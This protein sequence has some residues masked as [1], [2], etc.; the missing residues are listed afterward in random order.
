MSSIQENITALVNK[1]KSQ[2]GY[3]EPHH[4]N[5]NKYAEWIDKTYPPTEWYNGRKNVGGDWCTIFVDWCFLD[6]FGITQATKILNRDSQYGKLAAVVQYMY[7]CLL[8]VDRV[9]KE[10]HVGDICFYHNDKYTGLAQLSHVGIVVKV[11]G[12]YIWVVEGNAGPNS[13]SVY[14][15]KIR[16]NY[17]T[18]AWGIYGFGYPDYKYGNIKPEPTPVPPTPS[19][20]PSTPFA[21]EILES[22]KTGIRAGRYSSTQY[23]GEIN[24]GIYTIN[25]IG[26]DYGKLDSMPGWIYLID[27]NI[28]ILG[29][30]VK[31]FTLGN[32]YHVI[33]RE[34]LNVRKSPSIHGDLVTSLKKGTEIRCRAITTDNEGNIWL[35]IDKPTNG[36]ICGIYHNEI[37]VG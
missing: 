23:L 21:V 35:R 31:G 29:H 26:G 16:K 27:K 15:R 33:C 22:G 25:E 8:A 36:W 17:D 24:K 6:T 18:K 3:K 20:Y 4:N 9:G 30:T 12:D 28:N 34:P 37:Y 2:L 5:Y 13:D 19:K 32:T 10:P 1:A 14:E 11:E 7:R